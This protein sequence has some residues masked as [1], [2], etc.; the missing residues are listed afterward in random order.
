MEVFQNNSFSG[1]FAKHV[2][3]HELKPNKTRSALQ[4]KGKIDFQKK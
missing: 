1:G 3:N 2:P 4:I